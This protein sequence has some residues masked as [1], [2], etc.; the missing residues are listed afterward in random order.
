MARIYLSSTFQDLQGY[1][2]E[3]YKALRQLRHDVLAMEDYLAQDERPL[4]R[5]IDDVQSCD[6]YVGLFAWRYGYVPK[7]ARNPDGH[8]ITECEYRAARAQGK[9]CLVFLLDPKAPWLPD[10]MDSQQG[11]GDGGALIK[12]LRDELAGGHLVKF[13]KDRYELA[14][15]VSSSVS[16]WE[17]DR[18]QAAAREAEEPGAPVVPQMRQLRFGALLAYSEVFD[19]AG[20][21]ALAEQLRG[22][23]VDVLQAP[24]ALFA[25]SADDYREVEQAVTQCHSAIVFLT[26]PAVDQLRALA[27]KVG[28]IVDM[29]EARTSCVLCVL[30]GVAAAELPASWHFTRV[31]EQQPGVGFDAQIVGELAVR[32]PTM[33][34]RT[35]GLPFVVIAMKAAEARALMQQP[36]ALQAELPAARY[37][38]FLKLRES[39]QQQGDPLT[40]YDEHRRDWRPF[41][42]KGVHAIAA[43]I[44]ERLNGQIG[45]G[46]RDRRIKLQYYPFDAWLD[47]TPELRPIYREIAASGCVAI[48]DEM[49][50]FQRELREAGAAFV[51][52]GQ[53]AVVTIAPLDASGSPV[54]Q[55]LESE[56]RQRLAGAFDRF[57]VELDPSCEFGIGEERRLKRWLHAS[58][59]ETLHNL[60]EPPPD[61][62]KLHRFRDAVGA[63]RKRGVDDLIYSPAANRSPA[64]PR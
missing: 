37:D 64:A 62:S 9:P 34:A 7:D 2:E 5:C 27:D 32:C 6:V 51:G 45:A 56:T 53:V 21:Y 59:P 25:E 52:S 40:R 57:E 38:Q 35:V 28:R 11:T 61:R 26:R 33:S 50:L 43:D 15:A 31:I 42:K 47:K 20:A 55:L 18:Q 4:E 41:G 39:M 44:V 63:E 46:M 12:K 30:E 8:S 60:R 10:Y 16:L 22:R 23:G 58:L 3:V 54:N 14:Q 17:K 29:L 19:Q 13:F 36:A 1:R 48:I 24:R 49:S